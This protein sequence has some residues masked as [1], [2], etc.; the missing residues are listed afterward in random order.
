MGIQIST[1]ARQVAHVSSDDFGLYI[2]FPY[3]LRICPYCDF[4]VYAGSFDG[5]RYAKAVISEIKSRASAYLKRGKL[6]SIYFGGGPPS[7][8]AAADMQEVLQCA[9][10]VFG[11]KED[12]E[13]TLECNPENLDKDYL[14]QVRNL[15]F[16]RISLGS[17]SLR[18]TELIQLGRVHRAEQTFDAIRAAQELGF[19]ISVDVIFGA[20]GQGKAHLQE[21]LCGLADQAIDHISSYALTI[22]ADTHFGRK[23]ASGDFVAMSDDEQAD[24]MSELCEFLAL[25]GFE[26]YE[27]SAFARGGKRAVHN[28]LYWVGAAYLGVGA[29]AHSYL[30]GG[31][32]T[33]AR[34]RQTVKNPDTYMNSAERLDFPTAF[35][36]SLDRLAVV[37]E[38]L[39]VGCRVK[40]GLDLRDLAWGADGEAKIAGLRR[41]IDELV[42]DGLLQGDA[43][44]IWPTERGLFFSDSIA[45]KLVIRASELLA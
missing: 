18:P 21:T 26:H 10:K 44:S 12:A 23:Q 45:R 16:N 22:E 27:V 41:E 25:H 1:D 24:R 14:A 6:R 28:S 20:P 30:P 2:H 37:S 3:C 8:W 42:A 7:L 38:A 35:V 9:N 40:W 33:A 29:G 5:R 11:I 19:S 43:F 15:G 36:E 4:N 34:R 32:E 31:G 13:I 39:M 17:Q